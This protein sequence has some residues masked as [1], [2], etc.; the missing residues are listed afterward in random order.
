MSVTA[1]IFDLDGV[2]VDS[3]HVWDEVRR[4]LTGEL[5]GNWAD[6][7]QPDMMGMSSTEWSAY[8]HDDLAVPLPLDEISDRVVAEMERRYSRELPL[9]PGAVE[10]VRA[11]A[12]IWPLGLASSANRPLIDLFLELSGLAQAFQTSVSSE[13]VARGKPAPDVYLRAAEL[14][15][16][17][18]A[19]CAG[20]E[21]SAN[22]I[23]AAAA[24]GLS[25]IAIPNEHYPPAPDALELA[26][27]TVR[28]ISE[29]TPGR[30]ERLS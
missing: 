14:M 5:G 19:S 15:G 17:D 20:V 21:D 9:I 30:V 8:M 25:V 16:V 18:P 29:L 23:R 27:V 24:A 4:D 12:D 1:L 7:A 6:R 13:E 11:L 26:T 10:C 3:E 2:L 22:G 28:S